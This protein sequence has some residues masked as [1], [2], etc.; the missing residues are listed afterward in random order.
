MN[1]IKEYNICFEKNQETTSGLFSPYL[2]E[3]YNIHNTSS[4]EVGTYLDVMNNDKDIFR[5]VR[6]KLSM[7]KNKQVINNTFLFM[8]YF[9]N[10]L[11]SNLQNDRFIDNTLKPMILKEDQ[12]GTVILD[13][14]F[15]NF[16]ISYF[17]EEEFSNSSWF[18][19]QKD[20]D[21]E[22]SFCGKLDLKNLHNAIS[23][24]LI[25]VLANT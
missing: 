5:N 10:I 7:L 12:D 13:W 24:S 23:G 3:I 18:I 20:K 6:P 19:L 17:I 22:S 1:L 9:Q 2:N 25:Y 8:S 15:K 16:Q 21:S 11:L 4:L 14:F